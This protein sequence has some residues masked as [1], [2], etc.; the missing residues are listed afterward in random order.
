MNP[1]VCR[2]P[3]LPLPF[4][5]RSSTLGLGIQILHLFT[6]FVDHHLATGLKQAVAFG[7]GTGD[8]GPVGGWEHVLTTR[9][10]HPHVYQHVR[11]CACVSLVSRIEMRNL[12]LFP[13]FF[14]LSE[15]AK[16]LLYHGVQPYSLLNPYRSWLLH[17]HAHL[18]PSVAPAIW[19]EIP[20]TSASNPYFSRL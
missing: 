16:M 18:W 9:S 14:P 1:R 19:V 11:N 20:M 7:M 4:P 8:R 10:Q 5:Q 3:A 12:H 17:P 6:S 13:T 2:G 15:T